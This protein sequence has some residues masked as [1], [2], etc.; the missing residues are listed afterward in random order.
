MAVT[1]IPSVANYKD[2]IESCLQQLSDGREDGDIDSAVFETECAQLLDQILAIRKDANS[3]AL[4]IHNAAVETVCREVVWDIVATVDISEPAFAQVWVLLD[5]INILSDNELC[6]PGL[7][8]WLVEELLDSQ[9]IEGCRKVFDYLE[10]RRE[11]MTA[12]HF[13]Q[14]NLVILRCCN[15][16]LRRLS[17]AED[18]VFCGRVFIFLFQS[19]PL[20]DKSSV[21]LRGEFHVEN[22]TDFDPRPVKSDD[23]IKPME[24]DDATP[25]AATSGA[26]TPASQA[27]D[28]EK[29][30]RS[31]PV[32]RVAKTEPKDQQPP[33]DLDAL[34]PRFWSLQSFFSAPTRLFDP[35]NMTAFKD[36]ISQTLSCFKS[37][38]SSSTASTTSPSDVKRGL[39]RKRSS[40]DTPASTSTFN[41][42]YLTNRDLFDL[43]I[44][45]IAFR[46]HI[47]VQALIMIDYLLSLSSASKAKFEGLTNKSV[48][49]PYTLSEDDAKWAQSTRSQIA[50]YL[51]QGGNGNEGKFY[52]R[53]V[54]TVLSRDKNW[55]RWKA[56]NCPPITRE[57]V[58]PEMYLQARD[59]LTKQ[60]ESARAPLVNPPGASDLAFLSKVE[61]LEALKNPSRRYKVPTPEEYYRGI[62]TDELD[63]DFATTEEE[64]RDIEERKAGKVWR[65]LRS[66]KNRFV[67]CEKVQYGGDCKPLIEE[68]KTEEHEEH[69]EKGAEGEGEDEV[70]DKREG[71]ENGTRAELKLEGDGEGE[72]E[73]QAQDAG[74]EKIETA[75]A[76]PPIEQ[77]EPREQ[78]GKEPD[79]VTKVE[80]AEMADVPPSAVPADTVDTKNE[81]VA[82]AS[83]DG[84]RDPGE[85]D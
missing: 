3:D 6:E 16:L 81:G 84:D 33:P 73:G 27:Q 36:G 64:K 42:K 19:F 22:V 41:P 85:T 70:K 58:S 76:P 82:G 74:S 2:L 31:T 69:G 12:K 17:R 61:P 24:L 50:T 35:S 56:E 14:K 51:Q 80:D 4:Q 72:V 37:V 21:N 54:D 7:G 55:V 57:G 10:S 77:E 26:H 15:E 47:L 11:K 46:R 75:L 53:M 40:V 49:Y 25:Q 29:T 39:K 68:V 62:E 23:A 65:A 79:T 20:G 48:L 13:K 52:Y 71:L 9:T 30:A 63:M 45:D 60:I 5:V 66:S 83:G 1:H 44:H 18:T 43:E 38:S 34:Y 32:L 67:M 28:T 8:F 59:T 78:P